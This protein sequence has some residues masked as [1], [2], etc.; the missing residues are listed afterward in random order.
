MSW[1]A[2]RN[3]KS[4]WTAQVDIGN[5][6]SAEL[7]LDSTKDSNKVVAFPV[8]FAGGPVDIKVTLNGVGGDGPSSFL[9][10]FQGLKISLDRQGS[11]KLTSY[12]TSCGG[13][14]M[15]AGMFTI[16][17][18]NVLATTLSGGVKGGFFVRVIGTKRVDQPLPGTCRLLAE[19][20][21]VQLL[22]A[23]ANGG[24]KE[25]FMVPANYNFTVTMQ[26]VPFDL[27]GS[28]IQ[29]SATNA[30]EVACSGF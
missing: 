3:A 8:K 15:D 11:C 24:Y 2:V 27:V 25:S 6:N 1:D 10:Q 21:V 28:E 5:D 30:W 9:T 7:S 19:P 17:N 29:A 18:N 22:Q 20:T 4:K 26:Y 16:G 23:D 13:A 12:G 14:R